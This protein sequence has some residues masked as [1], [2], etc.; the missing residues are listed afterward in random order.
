[1]SEWDELIFLVYKKFYLE[2]KKLVSA[3]R[4]KETNFFIES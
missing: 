2:R 4:F 3:I 1:M